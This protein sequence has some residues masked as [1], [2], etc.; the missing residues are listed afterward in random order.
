MK[1]YNIYQN[2]ILE[3]IFNKVQLTEGVSVEDI[4]KILTGDEN[5]P[6]KFYY[7]SFDYPDKEGNITKRWVQIFQRNISKTNNNLID[8]YQV[9]VDNNTS[10]PN[11]KRSSFTG[12]KKF[13]MAK[14]NNLKLSKVPY[15]QEPE[16]YTV[17][18][19]KGKVRIAKLNK[20]GNNS[21]NI[22]STPTIS[23]IGTYQYAPSTVKKMDR[24][25]QTPPENIGVQPTQQPTTRPQQRTQEPSPQ[26]TAKQPV[27]P[28][29]R[30]E[31]K[32]IEP[33]VKPEDE[34]EI[35]NN[36]ELNK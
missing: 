30:V 7:A 35:E 19:S 29:R 20:F 12:W 31:P 25:K 2:I 23:K 17:I 13:D 1:L 33:N 14:I 34:E 24:D 32:P 26:P 18:N 22:V 16:P 36:L 9:S 5:K 15:Y 6:G 8:A 4:E 3:E 28:M 10:K 27:R 11:N 21:K